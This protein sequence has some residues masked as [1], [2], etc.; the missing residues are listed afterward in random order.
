MLDDRR[1]PVGR[2]VLADDQVIS[3]LS[4]SREHDFFRSKSYIGEG[5]SEILLRPLPS[6]DVNP[7]GV[8]VNSDAWWLPQYV[9]GLSLSFSLEPLALGARGFGA[10]GLGAVTATAVATATGLGAVT[11]A[12]VATTTGLGAVTAAAVATATSLGAVATAT[13]L[14]AVATATSFGTSAVATTASFGAV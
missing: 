4:W 1:H 5:R 6:P 7:P 12:A 14:G 3:Q 8:Q 10:G 13:S 9:F 11:A 2:L